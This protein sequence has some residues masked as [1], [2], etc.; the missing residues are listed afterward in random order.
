MAFGVGIIGYGQQGRWHARTIEQSVPELT[1]VAVHDPTEACR[2]QARADRPAIPVHDSVQ[3]LLSDPGV[4]L[5]VIATP[6]TAHRPL[7]IAALEA[8]K[9]VVCEKPMALS[10]AEGQEMVEAAQRAGRVFSVFQNRRW[11]GYFLQAKTAIESGYLGRIL[12][13][14]MV[15]QTYAAGALTFGVREFRPQWRAERAFGGGML[16]DWGGHRLDQLLQLHKAPVRSV[17]AKLFNGHWLPSQDAD[18]GFRIEVTFADGVHAHV[19]QQ[20]LSMAGV[21]TGGWF[22]AGTKGGYRQGRISHLVEGRIFAADWPEPR[23]VEGF[24]PNLLRVVRGE[25][26]AVQAIQMRESLRV[27][28]LIDAVFAADASGQ[29]VA[30]E[31]A[32]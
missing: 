24:W 26:G 20:L 12:D 29:V 1:L 3:S 31:P 9:H 22:I 4:D 11:D 28:R 21:S 18:D 19:E 7:T 30:F 8:G 17:Y 14:G 10:A 32:L 27:M 6:T 25:P 23:G 16:Y 13:L 2:A 5:V 15:E